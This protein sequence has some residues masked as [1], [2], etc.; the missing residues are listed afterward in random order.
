MECY[1]TIFSPF[2]I[3]MRYE[4]IVSGTIKALQITIILNRLA[5]Y[6]RNR[7]ALAVNERPGS[8]RLAHSRLPRKA[9]LCR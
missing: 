6:I 5:Y 8:F 1:I 4:V 2:L 9:N 7:H 3:L